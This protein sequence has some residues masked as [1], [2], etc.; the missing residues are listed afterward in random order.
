MAEAANA[1]KAK[2]EPAPKIPVTMKDGRT[3]EFTER[4]KCITEE[5]PDGLRFNFK[6]GDQLEVRFTDLSALA[7]KFLAHGVKQKYQDE[8]ASAGDAEDAYEWVCDLH[9]RMLKGEWRETA[10]GGGGVSGA[11]LLVRALM[12]VF[13]KSRE[14]I[15]A[16]LADKSRKE[17]EVLREHAP[18]KAKI[19]EIKARAPKSADNAAKAEEL[20]RGLGQAA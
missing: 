1:A 12:E 16:Y 14:E 10:E 6:S 2:K 13:G 18:I 7:D 5:L 8:F 15:K 19:D 9:T 3:L 20:L 11:G 4:G 17:Q